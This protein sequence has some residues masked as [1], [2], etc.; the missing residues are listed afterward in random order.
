MNKKAN[1]FWISLVILIFVGIA[2]YHLT[3]LTTTGE[4]II[5]VKEKWIKYHYNDAK[6]LVSTD[7]GV[8]EISD[9]LTRWQ[10]RSSDLYGCIQTNSSY[11]I[12]YYGFRFGLLS[13]YKKIYYIGGCEIK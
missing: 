10:W 4:V 9:S 8:Y 5:D 11:H 12:K 6:Y 7:S 13:D 1:W 3:Y 2:F